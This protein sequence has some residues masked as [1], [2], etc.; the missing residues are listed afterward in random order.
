MEKITIFLLSIRIFRFLLFKK[1]IKDIFF[2]YLLKKIFFFVF[3]IYNIQILFDK[4]EKILKISSH[5][6]LNYKKSKSKYS[7][8]LI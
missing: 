3:K 5:F 7:K 4:I 8:N 1:N 6:F 2:Y